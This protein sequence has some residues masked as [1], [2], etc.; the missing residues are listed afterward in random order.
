[1]LDLTSYEAPHGVRRLVLQPVLFAATSLHQVNMRSAR[2]P[3]DI[4]AVAKQKNLP[5]IT[6]ML[7]WVSICTCSVG[8][9]VFGGCGFGGCVFGR[10]FSEKV[11]VQA[12]SIGGVEDY[13]G[14]SK[15]GEGS[16]RRRGSAENLLK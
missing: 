2:S 13:G 16:R 12:S 10:K 7:M 11:K 5:Q 9:A 8:I 1:M 14:R 4:T 6:V 3:D 15:L